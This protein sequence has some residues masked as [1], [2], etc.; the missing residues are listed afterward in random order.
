MSADLS[1]LVLMMGF[2]PGEE[3]CAMTCSGRL[4]LRRV[5]LAAVKQRREILEI[6]SLEERSDYK[7]ERESRNIGGKEVV[8]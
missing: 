1:G 3:F 4:Q 6:L 8:G 5:G 2:K 7:V